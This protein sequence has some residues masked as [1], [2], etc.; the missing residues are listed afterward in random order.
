[1]ARHL[2]PRRLVTTELYLYPPVYIPVWISVGLK[3]VAGAT[4]AVVRDAVKQALLQFLSPLPASPAAALADVQPLL[5]APPNP[6]TN[7]GWPLLKPVVAAELLAVASRVPG[8][9]L[10]NQVLIA[11]DTQPA[12]TQIPMTGLQL[13]MVA[14]ISVTV[15]D[16]LA[17]DQLRGTGITA[18]PPPAPGGRR[19]HPVPVVPDQC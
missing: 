3:T 8:V 5:T 17:I 13:P 19:F 10:V 9:L 16:A 15:G 7:Q 18:Q 2:D 4:V 6:S 12:V 14:G 11:Q 1:V